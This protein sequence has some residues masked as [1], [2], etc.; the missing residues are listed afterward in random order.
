MT[1]NQE[2]YVNYVLIV[3]VIISGYVHE[4]QWK[5][6]DRMEECLEVARSITH[7]RPNMTAFCVPEQQVKKP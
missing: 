1:Y 5:T 2:L 3:A 4:S 6:F 7:N